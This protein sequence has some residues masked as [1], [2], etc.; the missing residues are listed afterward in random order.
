M[1]TQTAGDFRH[2]EKRRGLNI[3]VTGVYAE[4]S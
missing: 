3:L 1:H 2:E 4:R